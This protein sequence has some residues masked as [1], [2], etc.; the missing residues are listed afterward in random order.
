[1]INGMKIVWQS[2][3]SL[4]LTVKK[5]NSFLSH[6]SYKTCEAEVLFYSPT[7][8]LKYLKDMKHTE[9]PHAS[10]VL[11][12]YHP[13]KGPCSSRIEIHKNI[14]CVQPQHCSFEHIPKKTYSSISVC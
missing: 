4:D 14:Y 10:F 12:S 5:K 6:V 8:D 3:A 1:M 9:K 13:M 2:V 11:M 7:E